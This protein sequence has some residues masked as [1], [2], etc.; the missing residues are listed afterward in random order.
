MEG[1]TTGTINIVGASAEAA[2]VQ[3]VFDVPD[4]ATVSP[5]GALPDG[6]TI[7]QTGDQVT[8]VNYDVPTYLDVT[9]PITVANLRR[10]S[11][12]SVG[13]LRYTFPSAAWINGSTLNAQYIM[14]GF[15]SLSSPA[16]PR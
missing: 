16:N 1:S 4:G 14:A 5:N 12:T 3:A 7:S 15:K 9:L 6:W 8:I 13:E 11:Y 10:G 2:E